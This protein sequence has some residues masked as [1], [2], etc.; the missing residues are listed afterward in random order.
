MRDK[1]MI[2]RVIYISILALMINGCS[3]TFILYK[4]GRGYYF[5]SER[6]ELNTM[7]CE[8]GDLNRVLERTSSITSEKK[9]LF[10]RYTCLEPDR[11]KI[12]E[13]F[14]TLTEDERKELKDSFRKEG[15]DINL[16]PCA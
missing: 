4:E 5:G 12:R 9:G 3:S 10:F 15:Y 6:K 13:L 7:L 11:V 14:S 8:R 16:V 2:K 1:G